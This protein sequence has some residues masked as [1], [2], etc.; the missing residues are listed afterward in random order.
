METGKNYPSDKCCPADTMEG[1]ISY[2]REFVDAW[3]LIR[4]KVRHHS[5]NDGQS[6]SGSYN[7]TSDQN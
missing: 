6:Y 1:S 3:H 4:I 2:L 7:R 5:V